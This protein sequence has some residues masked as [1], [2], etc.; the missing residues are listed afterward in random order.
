MDQSIP[1]VN[2]DFPSLLPI[3]MPTQS[4]DSVTDARVDAIIQRFSWFANED[5]IWAPQRPSVPI[6]QY[7]L[8]RRPQ[9]RC[10]ACL[11]GLLGQLGHMEGPHGCLYVQE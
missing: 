6:N 4:P 10:P 1:V 7:H 9:I 2:V 5:Y 8:R 3:Q 11:Q